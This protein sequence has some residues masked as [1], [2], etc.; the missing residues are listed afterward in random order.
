MAMTTLEE[1][2]ENITAA[3][4]TVAESLRGRRIF[5]TGGT[6][7]FGKWLLASFL[8]IDKAFGL[9]AHMTVL[10]RNPQTFLSLNPWFAAEPSLSYIQGDVRDFPFPQGPFD[11]VIHAATEASAKLERERPEEMYAVIVDGTRRALEFAEKKGVSRFMLTSSGAVYGTQPPEISHIDEEHPA[12]PLT[13]YGK[14]KLMA[15]KM[16]AAA[17][18]QN[19]FVT[20]FPRC[21]AFVG[22]HLNLDIHFAIGNFIRDCLEGRPIMIRG[23]GTP[24]RSYLYAADL[25]EWLWT[26]LL[27]GEHARPYNVGSEEALSI[28]DLAFKVRECA[29]TDNPVTLLGTPVP[30]APPTRYVP[31]IGRA[32]K[33]LGLFPRCPLDAAIRRTLSWHQTGPA[34][35]E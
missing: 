7:F 11:F 21:F 34:T 24:L 32:R 29:G 9:N 35:S 8:H 17:G 26:I 25:A 33:E 18:T 19:G 15:E 3:L 30:D 10:S 4:E 23:D 2:L 22:P 5:L 1:D 13:S 28:R 16:C 6:G 27:K 31:A 20:L 12:C 14:G